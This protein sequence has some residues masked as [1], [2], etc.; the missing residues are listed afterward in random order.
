MMKK[1]KEIKTEGLPEKVNDYLILTENM[2]I[3]VA[4]WTEGI[5]KKGFYWVIVCECCD[6]EDCLLVQE[7]VT[8]WSELPDYPTLE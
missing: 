5:R 8:H 4:T 6:P 7:H 1:W 2:D 3:Y